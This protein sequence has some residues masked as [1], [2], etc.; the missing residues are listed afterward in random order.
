MLKE[1]PERLANLR[2][3]YESV[4]GEPFRHF[5]CP[6]L[7]RDENVELCNA[8]IINKAFADSPK[9]MTIQRKDVDGW[10]G[11]MFEA[12]WVVIE[13]RG[14]HKLLDILTNKTLRQKLKPQFLRGG[15][16]V[17]H[18]FSS[19]RD[20][21]PEHTPIHLEG[22]G[23]PLRFVLKR[24]PSDILSN[25]DS[26]WEISIERDLRLPAL[27]S[28]LKAAHLTLFDMLGYRYVYSPSGR[29]LGYD[30]LGRFYL[31]NRGR[32]KREVLVRA[33]EHFNDYI[34][35]V[36][37]MLVAPR[38]EGT[39]SDRM[40]ALCMPR[41]TDIWGMIV[42]IRAGGVF[43]AVLVPTFS[44]PDTVDRYFRFLRQPFPRFETCLGKFEGSHWCIYTK[45]NK[46]LEWPPAAFD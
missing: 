15:K 1:S 42:F 12:D 25:E 5:F 27:V 37:P 34:G 41:V 46:V 17:D 39:V 16:P 19:S 35:I 4:V 10:F 8:H 29:Y 36:R 18:Y 3:D 21:P 7:Y 2:A 44:N 40:L 13:E 9:R 30:I 32:P 26:H 20:V 45:T 22:A 24:D 31:E 14:K 6:I 33:R 43:H 23:K 38:V 11:S 28:L